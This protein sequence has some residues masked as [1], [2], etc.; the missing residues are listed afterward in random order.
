MPPALRPLAVRFLPLGTLAACLLL[1]PAFAQAQLISSGT[2]QI[3]LAQYS[4]FGTNP[5]QT[6][7]VPVG[8]ADVDATLNASGYDVN[9]I[10]HLEYNY[11]DSSPGQTWLSVFATCE[12]EDEPAGGGGKAELDLNIYVQAPFYYRLD[13]NPYDPYGSV[14]VS[15]NGTSASAYY[16]FANGFPD[17]TFPFIYYD[18]SGTYLPV[19]W[20]NYVDEGFLPA[21]VYNMTAKAGAT[22]YRGFA[23]ESQLLVSLL[24][25]MQGDCDLDGYVGLDDLDSVLANWGNHVPTGVVQFGDLNR[26]GQVGL[27]DLDQVLM[28]WNANVQPPGMAIPEPATGLVLGMISLMALRGR[29]LT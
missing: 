23:Q 3:E 19:D 25:Q 20:D 27:D 21:G 6:M 8:L 17:G 22:L 7:N 1:L 16:D 11:L 15:F 13:A 24:I 26:D 18:Y 12:T 29:R 28:N 14:S 5:D 10:S 4:F 9:G 2:G